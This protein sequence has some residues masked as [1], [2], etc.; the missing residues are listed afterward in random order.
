MKIYSI[1]L[2]GILFLSCNPDSGTE[3]K[4]SISIND[5]IEVFYSGDATEKDAKKLGNFIRSRN[6][7]HEGRVEVSKKGETY[8]VNMVYDEDRYD[9]N[10]DLYLLHLSSIPKFFSTEVFGKKKTR[11]FLTDEKWE[12]VAEVKAPKKVKANSVSTVYYLGSVTS[13]E[14]YKL[15]NYLK[16]ANYFD[17][18]NTK[19]VILGIDKGEYTVRFI[20][21]K[22]KYR[23]NKE[24]ALNAFKIY[25]HM[26]STS[27]FGGQKANLILTDTKFNDIEKVGELSSQEK[28]QI[29]DLMDRLEHPEL[30]PEDSTLITTDST[31]Q[32]Y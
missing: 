18:E 21:D 3:K 6:I 24:A 12:E 23:D 17:G 15:S 2:A 13:Q 4:E 19:D 11:V 16:E 31:Y 30:Y 20:V 22:K 28:A 25:Q 32:D 14:A 29:S 9:K 27:A 26:I 7:T 1:L 10:P 8:R 5:E